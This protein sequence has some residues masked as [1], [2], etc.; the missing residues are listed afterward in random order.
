MVLEKGE[1]DLSQILKSK[2]ITK[3]EVKDYWRQIINAVNEIHKVGIVHTDLKPAN[4]LLVGKMLKLIDFGIANCIQDNKTSV[5]RN[6]QMGTL[7]YMSP[8]A[9]TQD[10]CR[11]SRASDV[12]S[13]GCILYYMVYRKTPYSDIKNQYSRFFAVQQ[14]KPILY[15][16]L[17]DLYLVDCLQGCLKHD[18]RER[19]TIEQLLKH[20]YLN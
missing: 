2:T 3:E 4:F 7:N 5:T 15:N 19:Y 16:G 9:L 8:E 13:L 12:W 10:H 11:I 17:T 20:P 18:R 14:G 1:H 6:C